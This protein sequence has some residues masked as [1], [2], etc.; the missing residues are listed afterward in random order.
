MRNELNKLTK[1]HSTLAERRFSEILKRL[2]I[3]FL[4][5]VKIEGR[6]IDFL[7]GIY[8]IEI[9]SHS[10]DVEKN[11]RLIQLGYNPIHFN[12]WEIKL[13]EDSIEEWLKNI[14]REQICSPHTGER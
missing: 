3:P 13:Y 9:D 8:A 10:Q 2:H 5:K 11:H 4:A 1:N 14:C 7:I 12:N 6:E